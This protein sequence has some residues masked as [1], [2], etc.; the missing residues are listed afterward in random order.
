MA[1]GFTVK[2]KGNKEEDFKTLE[3]IIQHSSN[4]EEVEEARQK[5]SAYYDK[6]K[7]KMRGKKIVFVYQGEIA[8]IL[9]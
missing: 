6:V 8:L 7:A 5:L 2:A 1:K 4:K 9:F 3:E